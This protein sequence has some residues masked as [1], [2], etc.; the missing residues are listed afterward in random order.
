[1]L[2]GG[3]QKLTLL[4]YPNKVA[5]IVFTYG[6]N[7]ACSFC[8]NPE[9]IRDN[10]NLRICESE[11]FEFLERRRGLLE[12]VCIT[13]GEPTLHSDLP[14]FI[15]K[16]KELGFAV[17]LDT[18]GTNPA[19]L[20][21]LIKNKM[22]D[23]IAMDIKAPLG[24]YEEITRRKIDLLAIE[25]SIKM[26]MESGLDYE[27][28]S[29]LVPGF[30]EAKDVIEMAKLIAGAKNYYLQNFISQGK[31]LDQTWEKKRSFMPEEMAEFRRQAEP[32]VTNCQIRL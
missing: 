3:L 21:G 22:I 11:V 16:I 18:N 27:F 5:A 6:C 29:T 13:G 26:I 14:D 9:L 10:K 32:Q 4:D 31:M 23:Y 17:K 7:F 24:R 28:R 30:H 19:M 12:G 25:K 20:Q 15:K 2:I 1:M 8:H